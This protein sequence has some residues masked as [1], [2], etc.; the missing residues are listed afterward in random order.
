MKSL[1]LA[2]SACAITCFIH[3][4]NIFWNVVDH[5]RKK[6]ESRRKYLSTCSWIVG[7]W[8]PVPVVFSISL[9]A[10]SFH[11]VVIGKNSEKRLIFRANKDQN[12]ARLFL[13]DWKLCRSWSIQ[14]AHLSSKSS[15]VWW[16]STVFY[17]L[18]LQKFQ[19]MTCK[20]STFVKD[21]QFYYSNNWPVYSMWVFDFI[22]YLS[23]W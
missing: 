22:V 8:R 20:D 3:I 21:R 23:I 13:T 9:S 2:I 16:Q 15:T 12:I 4:P 5:F 10:W 11:T 14:T 1:I 17:V 18:Q 6:S 19:Y 7:K